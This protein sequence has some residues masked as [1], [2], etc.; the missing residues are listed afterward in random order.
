VQAVDLGQDA[1]CAAQDDPSLAG[2]LDAAARAPEDLEAELELEP[3]D[4]LPA[5]VND[6]WRATASM[7]RR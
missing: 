7:V 2:E 4:L 1:L 6:P 3:A 5:F